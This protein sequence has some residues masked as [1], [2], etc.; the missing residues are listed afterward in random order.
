[1]FPLFDPEQ[2]RAASFTQP[3]VRVVEPSPRVIQGAS[4]P[5]HFHNNQNGGPISINLNV[6]PANENEK[7]PLCT[8]YVQ[9][10]GPGL[11]CEKCCTW[12]HPQCL[13]ITEEEL[14][15]SNK[16]MNHGFVTIVD[17]FVQIQL[18]G[19]IKREKMQ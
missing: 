17:L 12:F 10:D 19:V 7:C 4:Q 8:L 3:A 9:D 15:A 5:A 14:Q 18:N 16:V 13:F 6:D 11:F 1:M 2:P